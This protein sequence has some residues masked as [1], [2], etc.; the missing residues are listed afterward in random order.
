MAE[1][2]KIKD[3]LYEIDRLK[4]QV[5]E[6]RSECDRYGLR[7]HPIP[8]EFES[9]SENALPVLKEKG[10]KFGDVELD[11]SA[12]HNVLIEGDNYHALSVLS[13]THKGKINVIYIDPPYNTGSD[14]FRY[15]D[16]RISKE[17]PNGVE[18]PVGH[19]YRHTYWLSFMEKRLVLAKDLLVDGGVIFISIDDN[20]H[21][22][23]R[24]LC[25]K[26]FGEPNLLGVFT[27]VRKKK[28]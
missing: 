23:L 26:I 1:T 6:L 10:G 19:P 24:L 25:D 18:V 4:K 8:E 9:D 15:H 3:L 5:E 11:P 16:K 12:D 22:S 13:Y 2:P 17:F 27:W 21:A 14:G 28:G 7:W 20:E